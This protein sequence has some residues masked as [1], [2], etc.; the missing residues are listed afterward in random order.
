MIEQLSTLTLGQLTGDIAVVVVVLSTVLEFSKIKINPWSWLGRQFLK[1]FGKIGKAINAPV[2]SKLDDI[3]KRLD[4]LEEQNK[5]QD[6]QREEDKALDSRRRILRFADE[7]RRGDRHSYEH[8]NNVFDDIKFYNDYCHD[9]KNF[10]ND[11]AVISIKIIK[12][13][14]EKCTRED[15]FL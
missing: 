12:D 7:I 3:E 15:D 9:N 14:Y 4:K 10:K 1:L 13:T 11:R 2:T 6:A 5:M 8:F